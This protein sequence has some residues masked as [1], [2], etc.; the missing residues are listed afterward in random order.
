MLGE[1]LT[2]E[3]ET[4]QAFRQA[5]KLE[6]LGSILSNFPIKE[7]R[8]IGQ[9]YIGWCINRKGQ[10]AQNLFERVAEGSATYRPLALIE[11]A[12]TE[13][14]KGDLSSSVKYFT[15][16]IKYSQTPHT[17]VLAERSIA[18]FK[19][20]EG[21]HNKALNELK[22]ISPLI[23]YSQPIEQYQYLNSLAVELGEAGRIEEAQNVCRITLASPYAFAYPEWRE[24]EQDLAL[25]GYKSR[26]SVSV[27]Q[28]PG[29]LFY[30]PERE[31]YEASATPIKSGRARIFSLEKWK[32]KMVKEPNGDDTNPDTMSEQDMVMKLIQMLTTGEG[33]E[34]K[35]REL[36]KS[37]FK[38]F[39]GK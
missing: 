22:R 37:A 10:D 20:I 14:R 9:Y 27:K 36:L 17:V 24:T 31:A 13:A 2:H 21:D 16:A 30:L 7:Y 8:L 1:R 28:I 15:E 11:L 23:R 33:D 12:S 3:A 5:E 19:G 38:I 34:K 25:R 32:K 35:I 29:N 26:S 39:Y 6:E 18:A 4:A